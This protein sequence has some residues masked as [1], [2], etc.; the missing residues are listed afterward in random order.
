M[1]ML[2]MIKNPTLRRVV[3]IFGS[4]I[5]VGLLA[6]GGL[7]ALTGHSQFARAMIW[8][9]V[10]VDDIDKFPARAIKTST[11]SELSTKLDNKTADAFKNI[12]SS[13]GGGLDAVLNPDGSLDS[14]LANTDTNAFLV[15]KDGVLVHEWYG[16][17]IGRDTLQTSFSVSKSFLSTLIGIAIEQGK[18][19]SLDDPITKYIPEL[20]ERDA[21]FADISLKHLVTMSSGLSWEET[22]T[23]WGDP[24]NTYYA[25][26]LR[27]SALSATVKE[28]PG[29]NYVYNNYNP[30]LL[31]MA[32]ERATGKN[33]SEYMSEVLWAPLGAEADASWSLDSE[34]SGF[35][36]MES[37]LNARAIDFAR[38]GVMFANDGS[39]NGRQIVPAQWVQDATAI[40]AR[41]DPSE[42]YQYFWHVYQA[43]P[44]GTAPDFAAQGNLGQYIYV[45]SIEDVVIVRLGKDE[46]GVAWPWLMGTIAHQLDGS[47]GPASNPML[48]SPMQ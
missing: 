35:E 18:I 3:I 30:L 4:I 17:G 14:F 45:S 8:L 46:A 42:N 29:N 26:D 16:E 38:F 22:M 12:D 13:M 15:V 11:P 36:K 9:G 31:G 23:P 24:A 25:P 40:E 6:Y 19:G 21:A 48:T 41:T 33:V 27:A 7:V 43:G 32:L 5:A 34:A 20:L 44:Q 10:G 28:G 37:G 1:L 47:S 2:Q 39:F